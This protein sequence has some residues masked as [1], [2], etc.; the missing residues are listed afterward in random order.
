M[1][2]IQL[3]EVASRKHKSVVAIP[4]AEPAAV[5]AVPFP[6]YLEPIKL[7]R[8]ATKRHLLTL[9]L[10]F[11]PAPAV[12]SGYFPGSIRAGS[13]RISFDV[14]RQELPELNQYPET[15]AGFQAGFYPGS[16]LAK[17]LKSDY[18]VK[19][20]T[21]PQLD[22]Y[23]ATPVPEQ[24]FTAY[25]AQP[26]FIRQEQRKALTLPEL[27]EYPQPVLSAAVLPALFKVDILFRRDLGRVLRIAIPVPGL[28]PAPEPI[29]ESAF[30]MVLEARD[31]R[32]EIQAKD[33]S[34]EIQAKN[35]TMVIL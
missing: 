15:P 32:M 23:P 5:V 17:S 26:Y 10:N 21:V 1:A 35:T 22:T 9:E 4:W 29:P 16:A 25:L 14:T 27:N 13:N 2:E 7:K 20:Q 30:R 33:T 31:T 6:S 3:Y 19:L 18:K 12:E 28:A 8:R 24:P 11:Y 34:M